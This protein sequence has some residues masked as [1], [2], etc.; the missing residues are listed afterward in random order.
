MTILGRILKTSLVVMTACVATAWAVDGLDLPTKYAGNLVATQSNG[1][2]F[3][4]GGNRSATNELSVG[5]EL[6][7][8]YVTCDPSGPNGGDLWIGITGNLPKN[9]AQSQSIVILMQVQPDPMFPPPPPNVLSVAGLTGFGGGYNALLGLDGTILDPGFYP[10]TFIVVNRSVSGAP[11]SAT[12]GNAWLTSAGEL[13]YDTNI[14]SATAY[15][16]A[17][18]PPYTGFPLYMSVFMDPT[19]VDGV[20]ADETADGATQQANAATAKK[21]LRIRLSLSNANYGGV[22]A[23]NPAQTI[24][25]MAILAVQGSVPNPAPPPDNFQFS[26]VSNQ[27]LPPLSTADDPAAPCQLTR[28]TDQGACLATNKA[29]FDEL[30]SDPMATPPI[31]VGQQG[32]QFATINLANYQLGAPG[33]TGINASDIPNPTTGFPAGSL[34]TTQ[35]IH[36]SFGNQIGG[37][38]INWFEPGSELNQ[39]FVRVKDVNSNGLADADDFLE[40]AFTGNMEDNGNRVD[41]WIDADPVIGQNQIAGAS[42]RLAGWEGRK[43]DVGFAPEHCYQLNNAGGTLYIDHFKFNT[44]TSTWDA[45]FLGFSTVNGLSSSLSGGTNVNN[46]EFFLNNTNADGVVGG[47]PGAP[48]DPSTATKGMD[49]LISLQELLGVGSQIPCRVK[50]AVILAGNGDDAY[51]SNQFLPPL[52]ALTANIGGDTAPNKWDFGNVTP[53]APGN[54]AFAGDQYGSATVGRKK[55]DIVDAGDCCINL[56]D[57]DAFVTL[58]L[59]QNPNAGDV[60]WGD[61]VGSTPAP[62]GRVDGRDVQSFVNALFANSPCP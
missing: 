44:M 48:G 28:P 9:L 31:P 13:P 26:T 22:F 50:V 18:D 4:N 38:T 41:I 21:G 10:D 17:N 6:D 56:L 36:T 32:T 7:A 29:N 33:A 8:L 52:G 40:L 20:S 59:S 51:L 5:S 62:D 14:T 54:A 46:D 45:T 34:I 24:K 3:G 11:N 57:A 47:N 2:G 23:I 25:L 16:V 43:F 30:Y 61:F 39:L 27:I 35:Q 15:N 1:T 58:L 12:Y 53:P 42:G 55:G 60:F 19:N 37:Q 49:S